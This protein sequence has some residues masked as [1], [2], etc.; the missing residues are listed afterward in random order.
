VVCSNPAL[1]VTEPRLVVGEE[2][3]R[4]Q[5]SS[6]SHVGLV[7]HALQVLLDRVQ[8]DRQPLGDL[9]RLESLE[10]QPGELLLALR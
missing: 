9:G 5:L 1:V 4:H 10:H 7:E 3:L 8:R 2:D 6:A